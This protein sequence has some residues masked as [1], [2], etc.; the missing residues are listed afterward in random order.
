[1]V[2]EFIASGR[3][4]LRSCTSPAAGVGGTCGGKAT[5]PPDHEVLEPRFPHSWTPAGIATWRCTQCGNTAS[6]C[7]AKPEG[8][9]CIGLPKA[10]AAASGQGHLLWKFDATPGSPFASYVCCELCGASGSQLAWQNLSGPCLGK[11]TS[12]TTR[13]AWRRLQAGQHPHP[14]HKGHGL[15]FPGVPLPQRHAPKG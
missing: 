6:A 5:G 14:R 9:A 15:F 12:A 11:W 13:Q 10:V 3:A 1:M 2:S 7:P 4:A 8:G